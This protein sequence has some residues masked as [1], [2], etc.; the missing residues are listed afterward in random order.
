MRKQA[1][2]AGKAGKTPSDPQVLSCPGKGELNSLAY[3]DCTEPVGPV[4]V[5]LLS[6]KSGKQSNG[7]GASGQE[8]LRTSSVIPLPWTDGALLDLTGVIRAL[9]RYIII[10]SKKISDFKMKISDFKMKGVLCTLPWITI[11]RLP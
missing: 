3:Q 4:A 8:Y 11:Y 10:F 2:Q 1:L 9:D 7:R 6:S 5:S